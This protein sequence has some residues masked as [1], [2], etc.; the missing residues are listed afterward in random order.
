MY[1]LIGA[2]HF[3]VEIKL[4]TNLSGTGKQGFF[5]KTFT[6]KFININTRTECGLQNWNHHEHLPFALDSGLESL[7]GK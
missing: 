4:K 6:Y 2:N 5:L 7:S 3:D 1:E